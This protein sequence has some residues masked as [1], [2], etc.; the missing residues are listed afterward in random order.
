MFQCEQYI[1]NDTL[2]IC[3][4]VAISNI[5]SLLTFSKNYFG[6]PH[7]Y[8]GSLY[9]RN[10]NGLN[11][12]PKAPL[13]SG[14]QPGIICSGKNSY[15][16]MGVSILNKLIH[17]NLM[18]LWT[19]MQNQSNFFGLLIYK[20]STREHLLGRKNIWVSHTRIVVK[21]NGREMSHQPYSK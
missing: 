12:C 10:V 15:N 3:P 20:R 21:T 6:Q 9:Y 5:T 11:F 2:C 16:P 19:C 7:N 4:Q 1:S 18:G 14:L 13:W 17:E 8:N